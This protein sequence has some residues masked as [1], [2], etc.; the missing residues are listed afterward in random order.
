MWSQSISGFFL[1]IGK[2]MTLRIPLPITAVGAWKPLKMYIERGELVVVFRHLG[3]SSD[4]E[5][6]YQQH[7]NG[8]SDSSQ[9]QDR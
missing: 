3:Q 5:S 8:L 9:Y 4:T 6:K 1:T 2:T 7:Y